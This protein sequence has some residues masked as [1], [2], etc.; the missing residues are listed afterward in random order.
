MVAVRWFAVVVAGVVVAGSGAVTRDASAAEETWREVPLPY[1]WPRF[2]LNDVAAASPANVWIGGQQGSLPIFA[3]PLNT[4]VWTDG[5]P[6]VRRWDGSRWREHALNGY[7]GSGAIRDVAASGQEAWV[8]GSAQGAPYVG[9]FDGTAFQR[10]TAPAELDDSVPSVHTGAAGTWLTGGLDGGGTA[11]YRWQGGAFVRQQLPPRVHALADVV[12]TGAAE[13]WTGGTRLVDGV[14]GVPLALRWRNGAWTEVPL[15]ADLGA[16]GLSSLAATAGGEV[17]ATAGP[18][19]SNVR[20]TAVLRRTGDAWTRVT[21]PA[22]TDVRPL[23]LLADGTGVP[24]L[25]AER[26]ANYFPTTLFRRTGTGW[27]RLPDAPAFL[28]GVTGVP[29]TSHLWGVG[30]RNGE[31][32]VAVTTTP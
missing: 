23:R 6:V 20:V 30:L 10:V 5:N 22:D 14:G 28:A 4:V 29:G 2:R 3:P 19:D 24:V 9:R 31:Q 27:T 32:P 11:L 12:A 18:A 25:T 1:F 26:Q 13:A 21:P 17:W 15:P 7:G 8:T 16:R